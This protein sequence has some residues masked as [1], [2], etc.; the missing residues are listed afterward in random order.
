MKNPDSGQNGVT[1]KNL[2][3]VLL[4]VS[5]AGGLGYLSGGPAGAATASGAYPYRNGLVSGELYEEARNAI[6]RVFSRR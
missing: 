4:E 3:K 6:T 5:I 2:L 1:M